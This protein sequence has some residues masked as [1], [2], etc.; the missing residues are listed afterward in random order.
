MSEL[1]VYATAHNDRSVWFKEGVFVVVRGNTTV[2]TLKLL[3]IVSSVAKCPLG[4]S[5]LHSR[6]LRSYPP[7]DPQLPRCHTPESTYGYDGLV[8]IA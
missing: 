3:K 8:R 5:P 2:M 1:L 4:R 6:T 7:N